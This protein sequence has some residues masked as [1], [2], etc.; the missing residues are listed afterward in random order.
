MLI[1]SPRETSCKLKLVCVLST[2]R[3]GAT[4]W[5]HKGSSGRQGPQNEP[6]FEE[7]PEDP[8]PL[9]KMSP[10]IAGPPQT[11]L[12]VPANGRRVNSVQG[13]HICIKPYAAVNQTRIWFPCTHCSVLTYAMRKEGARFGDLLLSLD[14]AQRSVMG[15]FTKSQSPSKASSSDSCLLD[16][17]DAQSLSASLSSSW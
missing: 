5:T 3:N 17:N 13:L 2:P 10:E 14:D 12:I 1:R 7:L 16:K 4:N 9:P 11:Q 15:C 8:L 6:R